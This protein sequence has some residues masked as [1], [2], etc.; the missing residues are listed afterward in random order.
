M[1][2]LKTVITISRNGPLQMTR[3]ALLNRAGYSV[4]ALTSDAEVMA[5]LALKERPAINLILMCHSVPET[6]RVSLCHAIKENIPNAPILMLYN[7]YDPTLAEVDGRLE[8]VE[9]PQALLDT[10]QLLIS[11]PVTS[12]A[13]RIQ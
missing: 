10:V 2:P 13:F 3:T 7:G 5:Y 6:S 9:S 12:E 8:N 11:K 1:G 4:V